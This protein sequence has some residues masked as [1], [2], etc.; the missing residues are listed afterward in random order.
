MNYGESAPHLRKAAVRILSQTTTSSNCE[1]NWSIFSLI[2]TKTMNRLT[3]HK[4]N[5]LVYYHYNLKLK[6]KTKE[7]KAMDDPAYCHINL[8]YIFKKEAS[9]HRSQGD[10]DSSH[11]EKQHR[12][13]ES[14]NERYKYSIH[15]LFDRI[16]T[17]NVRRRRY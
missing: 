14:R 2:H 1:R 17:V 6:N 9:H 3:M 12:T 16:T 15:V 10:D 5:K 8:N 7:R 13:D 11:A 4:P